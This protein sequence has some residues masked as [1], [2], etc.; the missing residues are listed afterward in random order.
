MTANPSSTD[1][2]D[3]A[4]EDKNSVQVPEYRQLSR[5][6][7]AVQQCGSNRH[8]FRKC[9]RTHATQRVP[10][11]HRERR[12]CATVRDAIHGIRAC[13]L[14]WL[15]LSSLCAGYASTL[16]PPAARYQVAHW[17]DWIAFTHGIGMM[18]KRAGSR[19]ALNC[20]ALVREQPR[21]RPTMR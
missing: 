9:A 16:W 20:C 12:M 2:W 19:M 1:I 18:G 6:G 4:H 7:S 21:G 17:M 8:W 5:W 3:R 15:T 13:D 10:P 11:E 14:K